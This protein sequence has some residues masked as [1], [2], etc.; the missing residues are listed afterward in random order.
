[1]EI[2]ATNVKDKRKRLKKLAL[3]LLTAFA[4]GIISAFIMIRFGWYLPCPFRAVTGYLCPG[5]GATRMSLSILQL[6]FESAFK[7]NGAL[8]LSL[9]FIVYLIGALCYNY[10]QK[11]N[12]KVGKKTELLAT[13]LAVL[14]V[15]FGILRNII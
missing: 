15:V 2:S 5:C 10:V 7:Y 13:V 1:M 9:P 8:F 11:G 12:L 4:V 6:D 3:I 14:L